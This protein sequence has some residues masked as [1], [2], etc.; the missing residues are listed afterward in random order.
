MLGPVI[1]KK[2]GIEQFAINPLLLTFFCIWIIVNW[3]PVLILLLGGASIETRVTQL[4]SMLNLDTALIVPALLTVSFIIVFPILTYYAYKYIIYFDKRK[5]LLK[6]EQD[7]EVVE[8]E[9]KRAK[10]KNRLKDSEYHSEVR[11]QRD[12][13]D[14]RYRL[15]ERKYALRMKK[16]KWEVKRKELQQRDDSVNL[17]YQTTHSQQIGVEKKSLGFQ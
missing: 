13:L 5:Q 14:H 2:Q 4:E 16:L 1:T 10:L 6:L 12:K 8:A 15:A 7:C 9:I 11:I 3:K 17:P